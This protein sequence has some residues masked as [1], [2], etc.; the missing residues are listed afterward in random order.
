M[1]AS[2]L[3]NSSNLIFDDFHSYLVGVKTVDPDLARI[4]EEATE[5][6]H[7][8]FNA[9]DSPDASDDRGHCVVCTHRLEFKTP[10]QAYRRNRAAAEFRPAPSHFV[11]SILFR[12]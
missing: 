7:R 8:C 5:W 2:P 1:R 9:F 3:S 6:V 10:L 4:G 12:T 11:S